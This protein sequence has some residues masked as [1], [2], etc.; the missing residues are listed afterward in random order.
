MVNIASFSHLLKRVDFD[1]TVD[2]LALM[3][4]FKCKAEL[5]TTRIKRLLELIRSYS[6]HLYYMEGK[7]MILSDFLSRQQHDDGNPHD[8]ILISFNMHSTLPERYF[9]IETKEKYLVQ[10]QFQTKSSR[11]I[12]SVVHGAKKILDTNLLHEKQRVIPQNKKGHW[13]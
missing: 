8:I 2:H 5:T 7:D 1:A 13:N 12:L 3:H 10:M 6:F 9:K 4:I 11:I